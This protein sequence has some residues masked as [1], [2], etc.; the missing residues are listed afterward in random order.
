MLKQNILAQNEFEN[1]SYVYHFHKTFTLSVHS[2]RVSL[3]SAWLSRLSASWEWVGPLDELLV[4]LRWG[5][6]VIL[7]VAALAVLTHCCLLP[8]TNL[9]S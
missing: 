9:G 2:R 3:Q 6:A 7:L 5:V 8:Y 1:E 4:H